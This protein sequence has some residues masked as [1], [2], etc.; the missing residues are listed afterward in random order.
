MEKKLKLP[1]RLFLGFNLSHHEH[2]IIIRAA[3]EKDI[4]ILFE[5]GQK[6]WQ[7]W[8]DK[9]T[10]IWYER[11]ALTEW[12]K[13]PESD[14]LL[15]AADGEALLGMC[16][17]YDMRT[18]ALF[19]AFFVEERYRGNGIGKMMFERV[20]DIFNARG[21]YDFDL[22]VDPDNLNALKFYERR[23]YKKA[24]TYTWM[25]KTVK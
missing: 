20:E 9:E 2:M 15:V 8:T 16:F 23:G 5:W 19:D 13:K 21:V 17:V 11:G 24:N 12:I 3:Q 14:L 4:D 18:W 7:L 22:L 6:N 10:K 25:I 1:V